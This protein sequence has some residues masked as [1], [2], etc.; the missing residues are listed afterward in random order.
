MKDGFEVLK[1]A[2]DAG[3]KS[4]PVAVIAEEQVWL[5]YDV[6]PHREPVVGDPEDLKRLRHR[7]TV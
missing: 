5:D 2:V 4:S 3:A 7:G 1:K 6:D